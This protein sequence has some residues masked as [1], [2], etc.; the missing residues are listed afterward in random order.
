[1]KFT[2]FLKPPEKLKSKGTEGRSGTMKKKKKGGTMDYV[3]KLSA[4]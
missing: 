2:R 1:M 3:S 4:Q